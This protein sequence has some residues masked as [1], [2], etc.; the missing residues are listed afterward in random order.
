[1]FSK[2]PTLEI[3]NVN[4]KCCCF[5]IN[6]IYIKTYT[7]VDTIL[8]IRYDLDEVYFELIKEYKFLKI[9][10]ALKNYISF[11]SHYNFSIK[12]YKKA[13][14]LISGVKLCFKVQ[15][16]FFRTKYFKEIKLPTMF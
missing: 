12:I 16:L 13:V 6:L 5:E 7:I 11:T 15:L 1:M 3:I 10:M 14:F 9:K 4:K 8:L 2:P